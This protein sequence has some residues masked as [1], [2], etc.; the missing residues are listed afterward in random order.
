MPKEFKH[1]FIKCDTDLGDYVEQNY[2]LKS[3]DRPKMLTV[4]L[5]LSS[6]THYLNL[7]L[8]HIFTLH[9]C[10]AICHL[11]KLYIDSTY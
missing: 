11:G 5:K 3:L 8:C 10:W 9:I 7:L 2:Y 1:E 4:P 6:F